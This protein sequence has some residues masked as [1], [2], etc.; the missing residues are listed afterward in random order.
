MY[1]KLHKHQSRDGSIIETKNQIKFLYFLD[2][3]IQ[4]AFQ[5][6]IFDSLTSSKLNL[7][8]QQLIIFFSTNWTQRLND[9]QPLS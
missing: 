3:Q 2:N 4:T 9:F 6:S 7:Q 5:L 1:Q 8:D